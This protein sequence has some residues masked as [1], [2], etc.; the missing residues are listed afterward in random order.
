MEPWKPNVTVAAVIERDG[1]YLLIEEHTREGLRLNQPAGHLDPFETPQ[2]GV[3]REALE[4]TG[5]RVRARS[6]VG[7]S[8]S[9]YRHEGSGTDVTYLRFA[10]DC[11]PLEDTGAELD[12]GIVRAVWMTPAE[13][14]ESVARHRSPQVLQTMERHLAG[15]RH[16]LTLIQVHA[17]CLERDV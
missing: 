15:E 4:E 11:E 1:R 8:M 9:R 16:P 6:L 3:E 10:F 5:W 12:E 2:Q 7:V 17:S 14:R 13:V